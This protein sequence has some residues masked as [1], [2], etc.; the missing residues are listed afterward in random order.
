[1][2]ISFYS[3]LNDYYPKRL[4]PV[5]GAQKYYFFSINH[6]IEMGVSA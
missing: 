3:E 2:T 1:M 6:V 5:K 4:E